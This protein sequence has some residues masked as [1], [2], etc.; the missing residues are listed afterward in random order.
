VGTRVGAPMLYAYSLVHS[1][2]SVKPVEEDHPFSARRQ[3][4]LFLSRAAATG[5]KACSVRTEKCR[6][7]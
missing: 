6:K 3:Y 5:K 1:D 4:I 7:E 2:G